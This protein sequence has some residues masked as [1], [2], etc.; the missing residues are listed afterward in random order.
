MTPVLRSSTPVPI[1]LAVSP[2]QREIIMLVTGSCWL[3]SWLSC[4]LWIEHCHNSLTSSAT[5]TVFN[6]SSHLPL[7]GDLEDHPFCPQ[8]LGSLEPMI[9]IAPP[10]LTSLD[11]GFGFHSGTRV[12]FLL[13][14]LAFFSKSKKLLTPLPFS[15]KLPAGSSHFPCLPVE[16]SPFMD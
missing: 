7:S 12:T 10:L 4:L 8:L 16:T 11:R 15:L 9:F 14:T 13:N 5:G 1:S 3:G 6:P 2:Q